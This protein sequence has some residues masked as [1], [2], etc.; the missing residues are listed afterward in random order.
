MH[1]K[2]EKV[3]Q[4]NVTETAESWRRNTEGINQI[5]YDICVYIYIHEIHK[6][7]IHTYV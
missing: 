2:K 1:R 6:L 4:C 3:E 7:Y 5:D